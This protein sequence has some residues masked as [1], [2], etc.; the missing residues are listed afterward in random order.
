LHR[1]PIS[2]HHYSSALEQFGIDCYNPTYLL[3]VVM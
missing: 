3:N 2:S 1:L